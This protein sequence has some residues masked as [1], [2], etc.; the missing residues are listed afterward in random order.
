M[1]G[2]DFEEILNFFLF[3]DG[4]LRDGWDRWV[5]EVIYHQSKGIETLIEFATMLSQTTHHN[6][7]HE[8]MM[9]VC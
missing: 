9:S 5:V 3:L 7:Q 8:N 2:S 1:G 4:F 6:S